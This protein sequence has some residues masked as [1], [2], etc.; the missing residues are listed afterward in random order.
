MSS[1][2]AAS[3]R[4]KLQDVMDAIADGCYHDLTTC[5]PSL[6]ETGSLQ[7]RIRAF[8]DEYRRHQQGAVQQQQNLFQLARV[9][10]VSLSEVTTVMGGGGG[11]KLGVDKNISSEDEERHIS[12]WLEDMKSRKSGS[13]SLGQYYQEERPSHYHS[14][15]STT[16]SQLNCCETTPVFQRTLEFSGS[17]DPEMNMSQTLALGLLHGGQSGAPQLGLPDIGVLLWLEEEETWKFHGVVCLPAGSEKG[18][19]AEG[20]CRI[21]EQEDAPPTVVTR[22]TTTTQRTREQLQKFP[23]S[24]YHAQEDDDDSDDDYWGQYGDP[25]SDNEDTSSKSSGSRDGDASCCPLEVVVSYPSSSS[26]SSNTAL[27]PLTYNPHHYPTVTVNT[28]TATTTENGNTIF[29]EAFTRNFTGRAPNNCQWEEVD[30]DE[31]DD[32]E[33]WGKYGD[34][35]GVLLEPGQVDPSALSLRLMNLIAHHA[36]PTGFSTE[37]Q[38]NNYLQQRQRYHCD[39]SED[40]DLRDSEASTDDEEDKE[41]GGF[42]IRLDSRLRHYHDAVTPLFLAFESEYLPDVEDT[43]RNNGDSVPLDAI[44]INSAFQEYTDPRSDNT[45]NNRNNCLDAFTLLTEHECEQ[46]ERDDFLRSLRAMAQQAKTIL[47]LSKADLLDILDQ[48]YDSP[49]SVS[50]ATAIH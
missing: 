43:N 17:R 19:I 3:V 38:T 29:T 7:Q 22:A 15:T 21:Q 39:S 16:T 13:M 28:P 10:L 1:R 42:L 8:S 6:S 26:A 45:I 23:A 25:D 47:G 50:T 41:G 30:D 35:D 5:T 32:D 11:Y 27:S 31:D 40:D 14:T 12:Q 48:T 49:S 9:I 46:V 36:D 44:N 24:K 4:A 33:Y 34:H 18:L 20:W 37:Q 2:T